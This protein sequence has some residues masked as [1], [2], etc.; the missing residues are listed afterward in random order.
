MMAFDLEE[1]RKIAEDE[2]KLGLL[3]KIAF[4]RLDANRR[5]YL[6][7]GDIRSLFQEVSDEIELP[8]SDTDLD[9]IFV[10]ID[11][12]SDSRVYMD[13]FKKFLREMIIYLANKNN[14]L[15]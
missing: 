10:E 3:A 7:K 6:A 1:M 11:E 5:G 12:N 14:N 8:I 9:E 2:E 15:F 13:E 4:E